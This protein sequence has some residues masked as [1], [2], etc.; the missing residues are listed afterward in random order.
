MLIPNIRNK[1]S[2]GRGFVLLTVLM[3]L[4][5]FTGVSIS[6]LY[7]VTASIKGTGYMRERVQTFYEADG[8]WQAVFG[9]M[10]ERSLTNV[11]DADFASEYQGTALQ[12]AVQIGDLRVAK[13]RVPGFSGELLGRDIVLTGED[14]VS[15]KAFVEVLV[16]IGQTQV[17]GGY[18]NE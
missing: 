16:F 8:G 13:R 5:L 6:T 18:G 12:Y 17:S 14:I 10:C 4:I 2:G 7:A 15:G 9:Y 3:V 11:R 1:C